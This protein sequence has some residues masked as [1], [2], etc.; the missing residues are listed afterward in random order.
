VLPTTLS[1]DESNGGLGV[2]MTFE[3]VIVW[4]EHVPR[5]RF[6]RTRWKNLIYRERQAHDI[7]R[8]GL[9]ERLH[10]LRGE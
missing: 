8:Q 7:I 4:P 1:T 10:M 6:P 3:R 9:H 2:R 5:T